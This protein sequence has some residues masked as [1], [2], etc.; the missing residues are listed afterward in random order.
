MNRQKYPEPVERMSPS[1]RLYKNIST[2]YYK[3]SSDVPIKPRVPELRT[4]KP[5]DQDIADYQNSISK[6]DELKSKYDKDMILRVGEIKEKAEE[7]IED[8]FD[9]NFN[10]DDQKSYEKFIS[11]MYFLA[12][13]F[14]RSEDHETVCDQFERLMSLYRIMID[15]I[16]KLTNA[17]KSVTSRLIM[18]EKG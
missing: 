14:A 17:N 15:Y 7:F 2:G 10:K 9:A 12:K 18:S 3:T 6:Y 5:T 13:E 4:L 8:L 11:E 1:E 16:Q